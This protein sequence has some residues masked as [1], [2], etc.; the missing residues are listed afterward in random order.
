MKIKGKTTV[1]NEYTPGWRKVDIQKWYLFIIGETEE[2]YKFLYK[3]ALQLHEGGL[4]D[5]GAHP[6]TRKSLWV[7]NIEKGRQL[8]S[9]VQNPLWENETVA[10][11]DWR[12]LIF[13]SILHALHIREEV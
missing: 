9:L 3:V 5:I 11:N 1:C 2:E 10:E 8:M 4:P 12:S 7:G 6:E 13:G